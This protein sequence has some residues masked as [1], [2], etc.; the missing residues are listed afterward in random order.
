M[1]AKESDLKSLPIVSVVMNCYNSETY[2]EEALESIQSQGILNF[3]LIFWDNQSTDRSAE[4]FKR[5]KDDRFKYFY[6]P[7]HTSLGEARNLAVSMA[8]G[9]WLAFIDCD[10]IWSVDKLE[11]QLAAT[12]KEDGN[13]GLVY[14][15]FNIKIEDQNNS[16]QRT[17]AMYYETIKVVPHGPKD[18]FEK[19]LEENSILF[20]SV[21]MLRE[22]FTQV[23]GIDPVLRQLED[24]DLLLKVS[25]CTHAICIN[26]LFVTYRIHTTNNSHFQS[27]LSYQE[28]NYIFDSLPQTNAV[29]RAKERNASRL[30]FIYISNGA[31]V[32]GMSYIIRNGSI[33]WVLKRAFQRSYR[34]LISKF[35]NIYLLVSR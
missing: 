21:L 13:V 26:K 5:F 11:A 20:S 15:L 27:E 7:R 23:G 24:Y 2:L 18:I 29:K 6:A 4:I 14:G 8:Q 33:Y 17:S 30:G 16:V 28:F 32:A 10:D 31:L 25:M 9:K 34:S 3:E 19:L 35:L 12:L 22:L 1:T